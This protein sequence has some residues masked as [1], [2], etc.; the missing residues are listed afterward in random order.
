VEGTG[1]RGERAFVLRRLHEMLADLVR[2]DLAVLG[3]TRPSSQREMLVEYVT[4]AF[5]AVMTWWLDEGAKLPVG[6]VDE[7]FRRVAMQGLAAE[8]RSR[9]KGPSSPSLAA[10]KKPGLSLV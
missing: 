8:L 3:M 5:M 1:G 10:H 6:E 7:V 9:A 2:N 4:G